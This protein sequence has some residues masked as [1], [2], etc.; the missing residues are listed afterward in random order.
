MAMSL[1]MLPSPPCHNPPIKVLQVAPVPVGKS[2]KRHPYYLRLGWETSNGISS[3]PSCTGFDT[4][5]GP[6][7]HASNNLNSPKPGSIRKPLLT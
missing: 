2:P 4:S 1:F 3:A 6:P 5:S 7:P